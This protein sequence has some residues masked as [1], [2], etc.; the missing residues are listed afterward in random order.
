MPC[1][2]LSPTYT[3]GAVKVWGRLHGERILS[4]VKNLTCHS[5]GLIDGWGNSKSKAC[6]VSM[7]DVK[8]TIGLH[9]VLIILARESHSSI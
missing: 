5:V 6:P 4:F 7:K 9:S 8:G 2:A 3:A 1:H